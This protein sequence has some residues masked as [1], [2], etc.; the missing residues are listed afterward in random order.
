MSGTG[1][2]NESTC[3]AR[4]CVLRCCVPPGVGP[5]T[6][7][8]TKVTS[9]LPV[10]FVMN[11]L[12]PHSPPRSDGSQMDGSGLSQLSVNETL[13]ELGGG[14]ADAEPVTRGTATTKARASTDGKC[15]GD[16]NHSS[17]H[18]ASSVAPWGVPFYEAGRTCIAPRPQI[19]RESKD[20]RPSR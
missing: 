4:M 13:S 10:E 17:K 1:P 20:P 18:V 5:G 11:V 16:P 7:W 9:T 2:P 12:S 14:A 8:S 3:Q 15:G 6:M 19:V